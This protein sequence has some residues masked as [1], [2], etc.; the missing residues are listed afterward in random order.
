MCIV[1]VIIN[2]NALTSQ[3]APLNI[4]GGPILFT[5]RLGDTICSIKV[6]VTSSL[7][8]FIMNIGETKLSLAEN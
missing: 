5:F 4:L 8:I 7:N 6:S 2:H 1:T 3:L